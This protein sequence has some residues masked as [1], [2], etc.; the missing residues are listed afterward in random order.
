MFLF[1]V[2]KDRISNFIKDGDYHPK[3]ANHYPEGQG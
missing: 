2:P 1:V 3:L